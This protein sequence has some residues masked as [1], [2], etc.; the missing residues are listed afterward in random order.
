MHSTPASAPHQ[1]QYKHMNTTT[2]VQIPASN[3]Q[4]HN[5]QISHKNSHSNFI[6]KPV[7]WEHSASLPKIAQQRT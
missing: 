5:Q 7:K 3:L 2:S 6:V 4:L 1:H